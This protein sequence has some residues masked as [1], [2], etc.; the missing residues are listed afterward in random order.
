MY[1]FITEATEIISGTNN[2]THPLYVEATKV[3]SGKD[4]KSLYYMKNFL[5]SVEN[6]LKKSDNRF[7]TDSAGNINELFGV[8]H[9]K[10]GLDILKEAKVST[11]KYL[12]NIFDILQKY[13]NIY[14]EG[15]NRTIYLIV[16]EYNAAV[17]LLEM[18]ITYSL[19][20]IGMD[21]DIKGIKLIAKDR[22]P[23]KMEKL[24]INLSNELSKTSHKIYLDKLLKIDVPPRS[25]KVEKEEKNNVKTEAV[26]LLAAGGAYIIIRDSISV[27]SKIFTQG[28][29]ILG[30]GVEMF[31]TF[32]KSLFG[33]IPLVRA[34]IY[35]K[36]NRRVD[37]ILKLEDSIE[38]LRKSI[39]ELKFDNT[40]SPEK[41]TELIKKREAY[42]EMWTKKAAKMR[43][44]FGVIED[45]AAESLA[46]DDETIRQNS[47]KADDEFVLEG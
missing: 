14:A 31:N 16:A 39:E 22:V 10:N 42:I 35:L 47:D 20:S 29:A 45:K 30:A 11:Y 38:F 1:D 26:S 5:I 44:E 4:K 37:K 46:K 33:I 40:V 19:T 36:Y 12:A 43:A 18:G 24:I 8:T 21:K 6:G 2:R 13:K 23:K 15:Y 7:I 34:V 32:V 27:L 9:I 28:G 41:K 3:A 25:T 17:S